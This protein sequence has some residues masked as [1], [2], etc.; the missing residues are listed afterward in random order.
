LK[1]LVTNKASQ[2]RM[3]DNIFNKKQRKHNNC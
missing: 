3:N 1:R 2:L